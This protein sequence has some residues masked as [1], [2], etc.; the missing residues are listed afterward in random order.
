MTLEWYFN[1][2]TSVNVKARYISFTFRFSRYHRFLVLY[3][4]KFAVTIFRELTMVGT[5]IINLINP[6]PSTFL[7][8][9]VENP[10][11]NFTFNIQQSKLF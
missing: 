7:L 8:T 4:I 9:Y 2:D 10:L 3:V 1:S 11:V 5:L 6:Q